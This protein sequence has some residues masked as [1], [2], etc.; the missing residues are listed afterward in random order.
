[1]SD[2]KTR[3][4]AKE[5]DEQWSDAVDVATKMRKAGPEMLR[6]AAGLRSAPDGYPARSLS[7]GTSPGSD[8]T[9]STE[10]SALADYPDDD[11]DKDFDDKGDPINHPG[12]D[13]RYI[14]IDR[15]DK[16][17][18]EFFASETTARA[19]LDKMQRCVS[20]V[21]RRRDVRVGERAAGAGP[22][23]ACLREVFGTSVDRLRTGFCHAENSCYSAFLAWRA[24]QDDDAP[25]EWF[26]AERRLALRI[27]DEG[28]ELE[29]HE[30]N[31][32]E[33]AVAEGRTGRHL[34]AEQ[35][36]REEQR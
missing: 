5:W 7:D 12:P 1:M 35:R 21:E 27:D 34:V 33:V 14:R 22:C 13:D 16:W 26:I 36:R 4:L 18:A 11:P 8:S 31:A 28:K 24:T 20:L 30:R 17:L 3:R 2:D 10:R 25:V 23:R 15:V 19:N 32:A 9:T 29:G 6:L